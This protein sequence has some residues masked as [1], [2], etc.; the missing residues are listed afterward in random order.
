M[1]GMEGL[2]KAFG[3]DPK[4]LQQNFEQLVGGTAKAVSDRFDVL[5]NRLNEIDRKLDILLEQSSVPYV[6]VNGQRVISF[7]ERKG[8]VGNS[9]DH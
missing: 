5:E 2:L 3:L 6:P 9:D 7:D 8:N 1:K 4:A